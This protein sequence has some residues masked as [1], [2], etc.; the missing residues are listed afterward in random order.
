MSDTVLNVL[1]YFL[2][3]GLA[4]TSLAFLLVEYRH[5]RRQGVERTNGSVE[6][7]APR[8]REPEESQEATDAPADSEESASSLPGDRT[9][10]GEAASAQTNDES[11]DSEEPPSSPEDEASSLEPTRRYSARRR[12]LQKLLN[13][14]VALEQNAPAQR[15]ATAISLKPLTRL[16]DVEA[17]E[18]DVEAELADR[19]RD[20]ALF[21]YEPPR[22]PL[23]G[24]AMLALDDP[25]RRRLRQRVHQLETIVKRTR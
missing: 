12:R 25:L 22:S 2:L 19:P 16:D 14:G 24:F 6:T 17:W 10:T 1:A 8:E 7:H 18:A 13:R 20:I 5:R 9:V 3:F 4:G 11:P 15:I 21:Y 23:D